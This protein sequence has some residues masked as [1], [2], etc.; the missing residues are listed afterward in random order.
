MCNIYFRRLLI[1][2]T[3]TRS[4]A[5]VK[6]TSK[7]LN[8]LYEKESYTCKT[9]FQQMGQKVKSLYVYSSA[10]STHYL[11]RRINCCCVLQNLRLTRPCI[12]RHISPKE[13]F[14]LRKSHFFVKRPCMYTIYSL[15]MI[16]GPHVI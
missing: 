13:T 3:V 10:C 9:D 7:I 5:A 16:T 4:F 2:C 15:Y 14:L 12:R 11:E 8:F 1:I 6:E